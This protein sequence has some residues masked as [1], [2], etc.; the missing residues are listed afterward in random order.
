MPQLDIMSFST[1]IFWV[2]VGLSCVYS[3]LFRFVLPDILLNNKIRAAL[4]VKLEQTMEKSIEITNSKV[5]A[6]ASNLN[7]Q[8][9]I[10]KN[11]HFAGKA[12]VETVL[13]ET[14]LTKLNKQE[15]LSLCKVKANK[16]SGKFFNP[17]LVLFVP[18][19]EFILLVSFS[20]FF[21]IFYNFFVSDLINESLDLEINTLENKFASLVSLRQNNLLLAIAVRSELAER[22]IA[23]SNLQAS[24]VRSHTKLADIMETT[25]T[26]SDLISIIFKSIAK[27]TITKDLKPILKSLL[28][29][30]K[31]NFK[32]NLRQQNSAKKSPLAKDLDHILLMR[33]LLKNA[34]SLPVTFN[35]KSSAKKATRILARYKRIRAFVKPTGKRYAEVSSK[36]HKILLLRSLGRLVRLHKRYRIKKIPKKKPF[37]S[38]ARFF[39]FKPVVVIPEKPKFF[40]H[41]HASI[42]PIK[43]I[44]KQIRKRKSRF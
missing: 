17:F 15:L 28:I 29:N 26:Q 35:L 13:L 21:V 10:I 8:L 3:L 14:Y 40:S 7:K 12:N 2:L 41:Y 22:D 11:L 24:I 9:G 39:G 27:T 43:R 31:L 30:T 20:V 6:H 23:M 32:R 25:K 18:S 5:G 34:S 33:Y 37:F 4:L 38:F 42:R 19:D 1:Q 44:Y 36:A 16:L